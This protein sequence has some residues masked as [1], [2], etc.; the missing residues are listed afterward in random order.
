MIRYKGKYRRHFV[1]AASCL[2]GALWVYVTALFAAS[3]RNFVF[4]LVAAVVFSICAVAEISAWRKGNRSGRTSG[5]DMYV[6]NA[7][8]HGSKP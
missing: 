8:D 3:G 4:P 5:N 2:C 6:S 1:V 7:K